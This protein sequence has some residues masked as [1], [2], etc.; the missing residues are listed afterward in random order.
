MKPPS[1]TDRRKSSNLFDSEA[2]RED[3]IRSSILANNTAWLFVDNKELILI[4]VSSFKWPPKTKPSEMLSLIEGDSFDLRFK[5]GTV[6]CR[7]LAKGNMKKVEE[8]MNNYQQELDGG[9][10]PSE[11]RKTVLANPKAPVVDEVNFL[12]RGRAPVMN[13]TVVSLGKPAG[14]EKSKAPNSA[15]SQPVISAKKKNNTVKC[16]FFN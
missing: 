3:G 13:S 4:N 1:R 16:D 8:L 11:L 5:D 2:E 6:P 9:K 15:L 10:R 12:G 14:V 7:L